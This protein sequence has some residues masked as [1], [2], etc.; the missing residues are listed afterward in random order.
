[1]GRNK[2]TLKEKAAEALAYLDWWSLGIGDSWREI[3]ENICCFAGIKFPVEEDIPDLMKISKEAYMILVEKDPDMIKQNVIYYLDVKYS[4]VN[5][6]AFSTGAEKCVK[7]VH[8]L[9]D[10]I[11]SK[12]DT[13]DEECI[14]KVQELDKKFA[15]IDI[16]LV[17]T[18]YYIGSELWKYLS[19]AHYF[20]SNTSFVVGNVILDD[21]TEKVYGQYVCHMLFKNLDKGYAVF[22]NRR[23]S[24]IY[25]TVR[26]YSRKNNVITYGSPVLTMAV[27]KSKHS[28]ISL[29]EKMTYL[30]T[31]F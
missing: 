3:A 25:A 8:N 12:K 2:T 29:S 11:L 16:I 13:F 9:A 1:M 19:P 30:P 18:G 20:Q 6:I 28:L 26:E 22:F 23:G 5:T 15:S 14:Q 7:K 17:K 27:A 10:Y 4:M 31:K 21:D 24:R